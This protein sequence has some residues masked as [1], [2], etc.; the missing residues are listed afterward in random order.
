MTDQANDCGCCSG[1]E[2]PPHLRFNP[3]GLPAINYR[4]G[5]H[6]EFKA[7][8]LARLSSSEFPALAGLRTRDNDDF[9]VAWCDA[10]AMM[11][12]VLGFYQERIANESYLRTSVERRS[13]TELARLIGYQPSP[14]VA[15]STH[16][17]FTL[18]D[19][20][21]MP[22]L[23]A[24]PVTVPIGTRVQS[25]PGPDEQPQTFETVKP[26][27]ARVHWNSIPAQQSEAQTLPAGTRELYLAGVDTQLQP[28]DMLLLVGSERFA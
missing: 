14:G 18:E 26:V 1:S 25:V 8:L 11:F 13:I 28:G 19:A 7:A 4:I 9:T 6:G 3:P 10:G 24:G 16:L 21:G 12:D 27:L 22:S 5:R 23:A 2:R 17:A 20:P 15:A